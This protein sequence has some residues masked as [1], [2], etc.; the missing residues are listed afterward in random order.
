MDKKPKMLIVNPRIDDAKQWFGEFCKVYQVSNLEAAECILRVVKIDIFLLDVNNTE[1]LIIASWYKIRFPRAI[2]CLWT[3]QIQQLNCSLLIGMI[4][5]QKTSKNLVVPVI[6]NQWL[7]KNQEKWAMEKRM[8]ISRKLSPDLVRV[9]FREPKESLEAL[10][11]YL[12][13]DRHKAIMSVACREPSRPNQINF[14]LQLMRGCYADCR[15]CGTC[16]IRNVTKLSGHEI[17]AQVPHLTETSKAF[18][19]L[20]GDDIS[21]GY[22]NGG[23]PIYC[24][25]ELCQAIDIIDYIDGLKVRHTVTTIGSEKVF[26]RLFSRLSDHNVSYHLSGHST[27]Q[28]LRNWLMPATK[29]ESLERMIGL[30]SEHHA[31]TG[32]RFTYCHMLIK[33]FNDSPEEADR[34]ADLIMGTPFDV[35]VMTISDG[36]LSLF[37]RK[38]A[39]GLLKRSV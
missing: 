7:L 10:H 9:Y 27:E 25:F 18:G 5:I 35:N 33:D 2:V 22:P 26:R 13:R 3:S 11:M 37:S 24:T 34:I 14:Y 12:K 16:R 31:R 1:E 30:C 28:K 36:C 29:E 38:V 15:M 23:D 21:I 4:C 8:E 20:K 17:A 6:M 32:Q 39:N 19:Y